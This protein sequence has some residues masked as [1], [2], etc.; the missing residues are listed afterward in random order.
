MSGVRYGVK[1]LSEGVME[2]RDVRR[3]SGREV[4]RTGVPGSM[5][6][7]GMQEV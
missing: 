2:R 6:G 5:Q 1:K 3:D 4:W 7:G